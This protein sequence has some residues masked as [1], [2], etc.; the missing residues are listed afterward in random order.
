MCGLCDHNSN[1]F[2]LSLEYA[3]AAA[4]EYLLIAL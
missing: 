2:S 4:A 3:N 1:L